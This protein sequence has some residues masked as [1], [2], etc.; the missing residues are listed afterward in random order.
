MQELTPGMIAALCYADVFNYPL[1]KEEV[2]KFAIKVPPKKFIQLKID[3]KSG[4]Y[5]L[6]GRNKLIPL[7]KKRALYSKEKLSI[8]KNAANFLQNIPTIQMI[9]VTGALAMNN[10]D[11]EDDIDLLIISKT[12]TVWTT[13]FFSIFLL[14]LLGK[15]RRPNDTQSSN[16]ICMNMFLDENHLM[17][18]EKEQDIFAAHE[19]AQIKI[20]WSRGEVEERF[21]EE[22]RWVKK[23]LSNY[24]LKI[25]NYEKNTKYNIQN[26]KYSLR[27]FE[28]MLM[29][30]QLNY[31]KN[32]RTHEVVKDGYLRFH[33]KDA[34][35]WVVPEY[36][37]RLEQVGLV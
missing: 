23:F 17:V 1:T 36:E 29:K 12:G 5:F 34:R 10:C 26:T 4:F 16:K 19:V 27:F 7:R 18:P 13:R 33:P 2:K 3:Q 15:R 6:K 32:R 35:N 37:K 31:M 8:A 14:E 25:T 24:K 21:C 28:N 9:A 30:I 11:K 20:L 22:N